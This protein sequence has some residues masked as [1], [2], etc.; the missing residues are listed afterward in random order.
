MKI[1]LLGMPSSGR[2]TVAKELC[3]SSRHYCYM[4]A[5]SWVQ[6]TFR[7][8]NPGERPQQFEDDYHQWFNNRLRHNPQLIVD[9]ISNCIETYGPE[10]NKHFV[11]DGLSSP[12]DFAQLFDYNQDMV[13]FLNRTNNSTEYKDYQNIG[14]SVMRDYCFWL[15]SAELLSK[16][17]WFEYNYTI[18]GEDSDWIKSL[19]HKNSVFIVK[20]TSKVI[21]HLSEHLLNLQDHQS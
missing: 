20:S 13:V 15:S 14:L 4:D 3:K 12:R 19:G 10:T 6:S 16:N 9:N 11:I 5:I 1:F 7:Q 18:P 2:T 17:R 21:S 8:P